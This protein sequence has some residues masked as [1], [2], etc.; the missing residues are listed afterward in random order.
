MFNIFI[1]ISYNIIDQNINS[2]DEAQNLEQ[3]S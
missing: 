3:K 2:N 1:S